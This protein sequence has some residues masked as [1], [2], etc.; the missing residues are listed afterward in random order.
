MSFGY[1]D[2]ENENIKPNGYEE[3]LLPKSKSGVESHY[4]V[5]T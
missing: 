2:A 3:D 1:K 4:E 5:E